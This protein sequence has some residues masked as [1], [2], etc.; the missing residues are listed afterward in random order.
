MINTR[1]VGAATVETHTQTDYCNPA[2]YAQTVNN[3]SCH[4]LQPALVQK[5]IVVMISSLRPGG[6]YKP[7]TAHIDVVVYNSVYS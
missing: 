2:A 5:H 1:A 7:H 6:C 4:C 3:V